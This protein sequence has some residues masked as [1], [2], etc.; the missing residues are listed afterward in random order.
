MDGVRLK[1]GLW[2][3]KRRGFWRGVR[4]GS[5]VPFPSYANP[6]VVERRSARFLYVRGVMLP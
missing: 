1:G 2:R 6:S 3:I 5:H 4:Q